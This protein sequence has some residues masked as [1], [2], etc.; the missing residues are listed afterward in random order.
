MPDSNP[1]TRTIPLPGWLKPFSLVDPVFRVVLV[2]SAVL[3]TFYSL[4]AVAHLFFLPDTINWIMSAMA[5]LSSGVIATI[6]YLHYRAGNSDRTD[7]ALGAIGLVVLLNCTVH[8]WVEQSFGNTINFVVYSLGIGLLITST[9]WFY[10]L[11]IAGVGS[12]ALAVAALGLDPA[13]SELEWLFIFTQV[14]AVILHHQRRSSEIALRKL[15][16]TLRTQADAL[17]SLVKSEELA[18]S[19]KQTMFH[20]I[21]TVASTVLNVD[22]TSI[23][24]YD[25]HSELICCEDSFSLSDRQI[26]QG[27]LIRYA[28]G[29]RYF[30]AI[31]S[32]RV[33]DANDAMND[34][35]TADLK[36]YLQENSINS[37]MDVPILIRG[38]IWGV[39]CFE[40]R[41]HRREWKLQEQSFAASVADIAALAIQG[42]ENTLLE[43][44]SLQAERLESMGVLAGGVAHDFNNLLTVIIGNTE[45]LRLKTEE[46]K[47]QGNI[48]SI[49]KA[50]ERARELAQ[51]ML[52]YSGRATFLAQTY[53]LS[54]ML[55]EYQESWTRDLLDGVQLDFELYR[56]SLGI[57]CDGTQIRQ[58]ITN[59]FTN[60]CD[61]GAS[62]IIVRTGV[63]A[64]ASITKPLVELPPSDPEQ[65]FAYFEIRDNGSG[66]PEE[67]RNKVFEPFFTTK[68]QG[69]GLG[70]AATLGIIKA[71]E[72]T[73]ELETS[74]GK[75]ST[76]RVFLPLEGVI[77][78][79]TI[80]SADTASLPSASYE[81]LV[82]IED[83]EE[84]AELAAEFLGESFRHIECYTSF[85]DAQDAIGR[86]DADAVSVALV[87]LSLGDGDGVELIRELQV[88]RANIPIVLM[89]GYDAEEALS[90]LQDR[91]LVSFLHKPFSHQ[92]LLNTLEH[93]IQTAD[94]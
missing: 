56:K 67:I 84:I 81:R 24:S 60:A 15:A 35:R 72:G 27:T 50:S 2:A 9:P 77:K 22:T 34:P 76:F 82:I 44:R 13:T 43:R 14:V 75:G 30:E 38:E 46:E 57:H 5:L 94:S 58:V 49:Q 25:Q 6:A 33:I 88:K 20:K 73:I 11:L 29:P 90:R 65:K 79:A 70:L 18:S 74:P 32:H 1:V 26:P 28:Q 31:K 87:D 52:A 86:L 39:I 12:W 41:G 59:L 83:E 45:L 80:P 91:R 47:I 69:S 40:H 63:R 10:S 8:I 89:S 53:D 3:G 64:T 71:H 78:P 48:D 68:V 55:R 23:W 36:A 51:Q 66:M 85:T 21:V 92:Q 4:L 54:D 19:D 42:H 37:M 17:N 16:N 62:R 7:L 61:S 93:A